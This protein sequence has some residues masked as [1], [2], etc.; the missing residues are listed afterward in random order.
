MCVW[1]FVN[2]CTNS[3]I[4]AIQQLGLSARLTNVSPGEITQPGHTISTIS[5]CFKHEYSS[6]NF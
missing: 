2:V 3:V 1:L 5:N 4:D 6:G